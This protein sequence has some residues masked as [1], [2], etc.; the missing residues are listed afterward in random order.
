MPKV[1]SESIHDVRAAL[2]A[3]RLQVNETNLTPLSKKTYLLHAEHFVRWL[4]DD[5]EPGERVA[6]RIVG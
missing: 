5:F 6:D 2:I 3:Y 1:R 4:S